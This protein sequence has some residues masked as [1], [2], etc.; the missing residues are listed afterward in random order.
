[1]GAKR[2]TRKEIVREDPI[3]VAF[4]Q[5]YSALLDY[6][7]YM[8]IGIVALA[9]IGAGAALGDRYFSKRD[10]EAQNLFGKAL[11]TFHASVQSSSPPPPDPD[12][13]QP[14]PQFKTDTEKY[15]EALKQFNQVAGKYFAGRVGL[16]AK[17][18]AALCQQKL[19]RP[20][21]AMKA[22]DALTGKGD[23][24]YRSLV[25]EAL[26]ELYDAKGDYASVIK[27][28]NELLND[29][30]SPFPKDEVLLNLGKAYEGSQ[31]K[32][33]AVKAYERLV[34]DYP[35]SPYMSEANTRLAKLG[36]KSPAPSGPGSLSLPSLE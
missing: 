1:M 6:K 13:P 32:S 10:A 36:V 30:N 9:V 3:R 2:L 28:D 29:N 22:L 25:K 26:V 7:N 14:Q 34:R 16:Y 12:H 33:E 18:Y 23:A 5:T 15:T 31:N 17:Y 11:D 27:L 19:G 24:R 4:K 8:V 35:T 21:E 20:D